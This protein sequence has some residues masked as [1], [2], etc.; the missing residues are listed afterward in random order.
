MTLE[1]APLSGCLSRATTRMCPR[2]CEVTSGIVDVFRPA[3]R[4]SHLVSYAIGDSLERLRSLLGCICG[5][6]MVWRAAVAQLSSTDGVRVGFQC[7]VG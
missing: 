6:F 2:G 4:V 5:D 3:L 7:H 1:S